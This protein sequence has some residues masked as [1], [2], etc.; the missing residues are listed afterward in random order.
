[1]GERSIGIPDDWMFGHPGM[2]NFPAFVV[3]DN[4]DIK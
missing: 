3:Q 4:K 1:M 2:D